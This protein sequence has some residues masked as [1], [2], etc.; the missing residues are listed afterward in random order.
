MWALLIG[1]AVV[2]IILAI[3]MRKG[4]GTGNTDMTDSSIPADSTAAAKEAS[5]D[6]VDKTAKADDAVPDPDGSGSDS[7]DLGDSGSDDGGSD[8]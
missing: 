1:V 7:G 2:I 3:L 8:D 5:A 4:S 6:S